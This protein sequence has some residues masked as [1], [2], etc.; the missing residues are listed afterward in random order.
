M[1][2]PVMNSGPAIAAN[3]IDMRRSLRCRPGTMKAHSCHSHIG[4]A[5]TMPETSEIFS[6]M[7]NGPVTSVNVSV[8]SSPC[9]SASR[10]TSLRNGS[11]SSSKISV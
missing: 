7:M 9:S 3:S 4:L 10:S 8:A 6:W 5:R 1:A 11:V 2:T